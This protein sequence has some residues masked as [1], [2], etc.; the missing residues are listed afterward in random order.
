M[1]F[2]SEGMRLRIPAG[3]LQIGFDERAK[4]TSSVTF[5]VLLDV[6][7]YWLD[8]GM[9]HTREATLTR[10]QLR[11]ADA[12]DDK[13]KATLLSEECQSGMVAICAAAFALDAFYGALISRRDL[14]RLAAVWRAARTPRHARIF[15][16]LRQSFSM[17][18]SEAKAIRGAI[19]ELF[20]FRDWAVHPPSEFKAPIA[21]PVIRSGVEWRFVAFS[22]PNAEKSIVNATKVIRLCLGRPRSGLNLEDWCSSGIQLMAPRSKRID[23][24]FAAERS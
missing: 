16:T 8:V 18:N 22:A 20:K 5:E 10:I 11:E 24:D 9:D 13:A 12:S 14:S 15:E 23:E 7:P 19:G 1:V 21:H 3:G 6:W 2:I 17:S 4:L